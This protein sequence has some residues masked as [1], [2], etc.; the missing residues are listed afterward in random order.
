MPRVDGFELIARV[1][2]DPTLRRLPVIVLSSRTSQGTRER[3]IAAGANVVLPKVPHKRGLA[4]ALAALLAE[5]SA[6]R[7]PDSSTG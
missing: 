7:P 3:A 2:R 5:S 6:A 4:D 1:R